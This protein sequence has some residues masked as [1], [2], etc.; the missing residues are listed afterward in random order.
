MKD[1]LAKKVPLK[2]THFACNL[3]HTCRCLAHNYARR[4][5]M[6]DRLAKNDDRCKV[7]L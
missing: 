5:V 7:L 1:K 3:Y 2:M 4:S 6:N